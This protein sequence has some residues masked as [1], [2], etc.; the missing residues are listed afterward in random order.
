MQIGVMIVIAP[1]VVKATPQLKKSSK[2]PKIIG[3]K[4][5][6]LNPKTD[7]IPNAMPVISGSDISVIIV[8]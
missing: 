3:E 8:L 4:I 5:V 2:M 7:W 1:M 6:A